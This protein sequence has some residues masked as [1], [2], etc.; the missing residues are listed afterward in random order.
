M[1]E[2]VFNELSNV[3]HQRNTFGDL[4]KGNTLEILHFF[5]HFFFLGIFMAIDKLFETIAELRCGLPGH[6]PELYSALN[7][8]LKVGIH[9]MDIFD[10]FE[11]LLVI[12]L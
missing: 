4:R 3:V 7:Q 6:S 12:V 2:F 8:L 9:C 5:S 1:A 11:Y 10:L